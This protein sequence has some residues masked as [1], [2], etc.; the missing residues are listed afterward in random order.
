MDFLNEPVKVWHI[1]L[2]VLML[3]ITFH[4]LQKQLNA[5]GSVILKIRDRLNPDDDD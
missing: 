2:I 4:N 3:T 5:I 1:L